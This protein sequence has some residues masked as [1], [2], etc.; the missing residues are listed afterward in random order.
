MHKFLAATLLSLLFLSSSH[1]DIIKKTALKE[2]PK[3]NEIS[4]VFMTYPDAL[5]LGLIEG[6]TEYLPVSSTGHLIIANHFLKLDNEDPVLNKLTGKP[7]LRSKAN[8]T[9]YYTL[10][11][12]IDAYSIIIQGGAI[13][14]VLF[15]YREKVFSIILGLIGKSKEG[16][17][18]TFN[19]IL[20]FLPAA[21]SGPLL[22]HWI[23][24]NLFQPWTVI[25]ALFLG[26][27][28]MLWINKIFIRTK[29]NTYDISQVASQEIE[30][31]TW[32]QCL[33]IGI[34]QCFA[35]WPGTS[36]SM[37][38]IVGGLLVGLNPRRAAEFSFLLGFI[39]LSAA[40]VYKL[41]KE[42]P[43]MVQVLDI[44]PAVFGCAVAFISAVL[45]IKWLI[46]YL[47]KHGL[48]LFAWYRIVLALV[49]TGTLYI[50][51]K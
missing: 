48:T 11:E 23:E 29:H 43:M 1:A 21:I 19:L 24:T 34:L 42:G 39:T 35:M 7:I 13:L 3:T 9:V 50:F 30:D 41:L 44:G 8:Q 28:L 6:I 49:L 5:I 33:F 12:A 10:K 37:M 15:L 17:K 45:A 18:L 2:E 20:A 4:G 40:S 47:N 32:K 27:F 14:A 22:N 16:S 38:T 31:L 26:A 36:R 25:L 51:N 46:S